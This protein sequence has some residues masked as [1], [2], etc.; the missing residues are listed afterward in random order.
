MKTRN[1]LTG[2][3]LFVASWAGAVACGGSSDATLGAAVPDASVDA[4]P[5]PTDDGALPPP[6]DTDSAP[7]PTKDAAPPADTVCSAAGTT[8]KDCTTC[9]ATN[10]ATGYEVVLATTLGC[11]CQDGVC[12]TEC[13]TTGCAATPTKPDAICQKCINETLTKP[14]GDAGT[15]ASDD[16]G[17]AGD[18]GK[19]V[20]GACR[21][22]VQDACGANADC[23]ALETCNATCPK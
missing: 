20:R 13:T 7:P 10:H 19:S 23:V 12:K 9:C 16:A 2:V 3:V 4:T 21:K 14:Q 8:H 11:V 22:A 6:V 18:G 1:G 17:D 5:A 15:D